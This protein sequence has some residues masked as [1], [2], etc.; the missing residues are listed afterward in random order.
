[1]PGNKPHNYTSSSQPGPNT[2]HLPTR[3]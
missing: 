2:W 3:L 1:M